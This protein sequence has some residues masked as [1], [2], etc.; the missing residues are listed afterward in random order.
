MRTRILIVTAAVAVG[1][2]APSQAAAVKNFSGKTSQN[3][4][5]K[6]TV[7]DDNLLQTLNVNWITR[8]CRK[9]SARFQ[10]R[11]VFRPPFDNS[12]PDAFDD[13]GAFTDRDQGGIRSRVSITLTGRRT[14]DPA[15]PAAE[16]WDGTL[17]ANVVVRRRGRVIDRC[18]L[19]QI[20]WTAGPVEI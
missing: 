18:V 6:L 7:G 8:R 12:T 1:L 4:T 5:I 17:K 15:N 19:R 2:I 10:H 14:F 9:S 20:T 3:R 11:T 13:A 16:K